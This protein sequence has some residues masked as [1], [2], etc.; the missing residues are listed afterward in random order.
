MEVF[1]EHDVSR[2][3]SNLLLSTELEY[4]SFGVGKLNLP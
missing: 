2:P 1:L 4:A 3:M